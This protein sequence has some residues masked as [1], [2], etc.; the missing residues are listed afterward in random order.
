MNKTITIGIGLG[1][2]G[3][4]MRVRTDLGTRVRTRSRAKVNG[5]QMALDRDASWPKK[6]ISN[7]S[8]TLSYMRVNK[9]RTI[10]IFHL[11]IVF[12]SIII[13]CFCSSTEVRPFHGPVS[14]FFAFEPH[15][16]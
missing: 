1:L 11:I 9:I 16:R 14:S 6:F 2:Q 12:E 3:P 4:T 13:L 8:C 7:H 15:E 5:T 10:F